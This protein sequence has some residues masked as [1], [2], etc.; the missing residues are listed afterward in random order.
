MKL[1]PRVTRTGVELVK[2]F[3]GLRRRAARLPD[4]GWTIGYGHTVSAREGAE[5]TPEDAEALLYY[6]L[7]EVAG[8][9]EAWT[10]TTLNQNQFEALSAFTFNIGLENFRNSTVLKRVNE[11]QHLLAGAA[12]EL[13]R[14]ADFNGEDL[15]VDAL[16]RRRAAEKAHYLTP[17]EGFRPSPSPVLK[18]TFDHSVIEAA[19]QAHA[20]RQAAVVDVPMEGETAMALVEAAPKPET[21]ISAPL[22]PMVEPVPE[23]HPMEA[24]V[25]A[26]PPLVGRSPEAPDAEKEPERGVQVAEPVDDRKGFDVPLFAEPAAGFAG[27]RGFE[28]P[29]RRFETDLSAYPP[30]PA[31]EAL[32]APG[33]P[34]LASEGQATSGFNLFDQPLPPATASVPLQTTRSMRLAADAEAPHGG[35]TGA[36]AEAS[37]TIRTR[38]ASEA[39]KNRVFL[40]ASIGVLGVFLFSLA[41]GNMAF[42]KASSANLGTLFIGVLGICLM[43]GA[44]V[45][46][47]TRHLNASASAIPAAQD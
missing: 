23:H 14:K 2:R 13:W 17:P 43:T 25:E 5:V 21:E 28:P 20:A 19:A 37:E 32:P 36:M 10:F 34:P 15:V 29:P 24:P 44:G 27:F 8:K 12:M 40:Y 9:L 26:D 42:G 7:S 3:E 6:D 39:A 38:F 18:P 22:T 16:V 41:V 47:L 31:N 33:P 4:G 11:G 46:F 1:H 45:W 35:F 30:E